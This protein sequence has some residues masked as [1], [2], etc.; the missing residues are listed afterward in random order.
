[1]ATTVLVIV[2]A[3]LSCASSGTTVDGLLWMMIISRGIL[4]VGVGGEYPCSSV[5]AGES[6]DEV[7]P[8][9]RGG[10]FVMVSFYFSDL[11]KAETNLHTRLQILLLISV[12][13]FQPLYP[14]YYS[15]SSRTTWSLFG[16]SL[17][18][19]VLYHLYLYFIVR[20]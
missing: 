19:L 20:H 1:V 17:L 2:G 12:M 14:L 7:A 4:G 16:V 10:L 18:V 11:L 15:P 5:S 13:L 3:A 9:K 6:A 8:G